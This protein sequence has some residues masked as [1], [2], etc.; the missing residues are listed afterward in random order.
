MF[1]NLT[2]ERLLK[3][4]LF[5]GGA[6]IVGMVLFNFSNPIAYALIALIFSYI[7]DPVVNRLQLAGMHRTLATSP[8]VATGLT[9]VIWISTSVIPIIANQIAIL[10]RQLQT[11]NLILIA[12]QREAHLHANF[13]F[14]PEGYLRDNISILADDLFNYG[15]LSDILGNLI[16]LFT[17]IGRASCRERV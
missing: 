5:A 1:K 2:F 3:T 4:L 9:S 12:S 10:T 16:G 13:D 17:K 11:E 14:T 15:R 7:L 8:V 6:V